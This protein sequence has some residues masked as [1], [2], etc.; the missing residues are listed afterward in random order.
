EHDGRWGR[1]GALHPDYTDHSGDDEGEPTGRHG[2]AAPP[3]DRD[4]VADRSGADDRLAV[5]DALGVLLESAAEVGQGVHLGSP[6]ASVR[7][8][9]MRSLASALLHWLL[10]VPTEQPRSSAVWASVRSSK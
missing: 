10:T 7:A 3:H 8:G 2:A 4:A 6:S 1:R 5:W 9:S